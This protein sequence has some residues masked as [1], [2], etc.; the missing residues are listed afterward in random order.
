MVGSR[1]RSR[2][3]DTAGL[4]T[5][6]FGFSKKS[7]RTALM[8]RDAKIDGALEEVR[9]GEDRLREMSAQL[10]DARREAGDLRSQNSD[11]EFKLKESAERFLAVER[12]ESPITNEGL[13]DVLHAAERALTRLTEAARRGAEEQLGETERTRSEL[14]AEIER[15]AEWRDQ[16]LPLTEATIQ[17]VEVSQATT[18]VLAA[19]LSKLAAVSAPPLPESVDEPSV[20]RLDDVATP[21][22]APESASSSVW[23][24][25][26][27]TPGPATRAP[28]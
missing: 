11:L 26:P 20:V 17:A 12:S 28:R 27:S 5:G 7:V 19:G 10:D 15:L 18:A 1:E 2:Q 23:A 22:P 13:T 14:V 8:D 4:K 24:P 9:K 6:L 3:V 21:T 16:V 25:A